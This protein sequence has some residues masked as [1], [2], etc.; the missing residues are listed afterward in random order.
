MCDSKDYAGV[1]TYA[2]LQKIAASVLVCAASIAALYHVALTFL[3]YVIDTSDPAFYRMRMLLLQI[4]VPCA[5]VYIISA[6]VWKTDYA[7]VMKAKIK[8]FFCWEQVLLILLG[9]LYIVSMISMNHVYMGDW[10][11][12]NLGGLIDGGVSILI[13]FPLGRVLV[14]EE[15]Q[16]YRN[17]VMLVTHVLV[18]GL[19]VLLGWVVVR[20]FNN[21]T[22]L[23]PR[24][25]I[26]M[27]SGTRLKLSSNPNTGSMYIAIFL[28]VAVCMVFWVKPLWLRVLYAL[29]VP[30]FYVIVTL[31]NSRAT[32]I[33]VIAAF[34]AIAAVCACTYVRGSSAKRAWIAIAASVLV[35]LLLFA[36]RE[37]VFL[38]Y[39]WFSHK[40]SQARKMEIFE[41]G[42]SGRFD[43]WLASLKVMVQ[44]VRTF[45]L[46]VS[47]AGSGPFLAEACN[48]PDVF[49]SHNQ[50]IEMGLCYG[51]PGFIAFTAWMV[52]IARDSL[53]LQFPGNA[54]V[55]PGG[56]IIPAIVLAMTLNNLAEAMLLY[57]GFF[58]G[59]IFILFCGM[60]V[61][62]AEGIRMSPVKQV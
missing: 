47:C 34:A 22:V 60:T 16:R 13:L 2:P 24:G 46:G 21:E 58:S 9:V 61:G 5:I 36:A 37:G 17:A 28:I 12:A 45:L 41:T 23:L 49:Y 20:L 44:D 43:I 42:L 32:Y 31:T 11:S 56:K 55:T 1:S 59:S 52:L 27:R 6:F 62:K 54:R 30:V 53:R 48:E 51:L 3:F 33:S 26:Y 40:G 7:E 8:A 29:S 18:I 57:Y 25:K 10:I 4:V 38:L 50:F 15:N 39:K 14:K 35:I 19:A